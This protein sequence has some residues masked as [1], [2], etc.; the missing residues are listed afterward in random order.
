MVA[1]SIGGDLYMEASAK[2]ADVKL[3]GAQIGGQLNMTD[4]KVTGSLNM[5]ST[6]IGSDLFMQGAEFA[7]VILRGAQIGGPAQHGRRQGHRHAQH[8]WGKHR[9]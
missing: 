2:F 9:R 7:E 6:N 4:A 1:A 8:G 3:S 5:D